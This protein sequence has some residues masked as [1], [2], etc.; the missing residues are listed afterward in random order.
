MDASDRFRWLRGALLVGAVY[1]GAGLTFATLAGRAGSSQMQATWRLAA[2]VI[3][4]AAFATHIGYE[5][6]RLRSSPGTTALHVSLTVAL[7]AF[8][9]AVAANLHARGASSQHHSLALTLALI[10]WPVAT[11]LPAFVVALAAAATLVLTR[12]SD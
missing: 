7:G 5:H 3:S 6:V 9:L 4:A 12:R 2:W 11:A 1:F 8:A 10:M